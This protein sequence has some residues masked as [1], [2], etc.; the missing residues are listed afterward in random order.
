MSIWAQVTGVMDLE[1]AGRVAMQRHGRHLAELRDRPDV[2][3][4]APGA[5]GWHAENARP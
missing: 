5:E 2:G 3:A 1:I 4:T